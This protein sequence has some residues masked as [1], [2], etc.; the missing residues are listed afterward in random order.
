MTAAPTAG[1]TGEYGSWQSL[2]H[3]VVCIGTGA[4][5]VRNI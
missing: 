3:D 1:A 5:V 4:I 2:I